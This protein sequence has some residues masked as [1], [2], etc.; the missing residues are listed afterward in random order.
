M[1]VIPLLKCQKPV[2]VYSLPFPSEINFLYLRNK[3]FYCISKT[4][5]IMS[6]PSPQ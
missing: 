4:C 2:F 5:S 1:N 3:K 6:V